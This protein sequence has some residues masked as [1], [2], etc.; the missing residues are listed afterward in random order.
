MED[1]IFGKKLNPNRQNRIQNNSKDTKRTFVRITNNPETISPYKTLR[2]VFPSLEPND[3]I[4][5]GTA[6]IS[7]KLSV[8]GGMVKNNVCRSLLN[9]I[10]IKISG[11]EL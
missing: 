3:V 8:T 9:Q 7:F 4:T 11:K 6:R 10:C 2:V 5:P 1:K